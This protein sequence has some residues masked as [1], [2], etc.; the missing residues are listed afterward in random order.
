MGYGDGGKYCRICPM[1]CFWDMHKNQPYVYV[2]KIHT[3]T[4]TADDLKK[5]YEEAENKK[6]TAEQLVQKIQEEFEEVQLR[7][8]EMVDQARRSIERLNQIALRTNPLSHRRLHRH[9]H[10]QREIRSQTRLEGASRPAD[11]GQGE[12]RADAEDRA[13]GLRSVRSAEAEVCGRE[14][15][16]T[17][18]AV[19]AAQP[20]NVSRTLRVVK[21]LSH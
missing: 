20:M 4:K 9:P 19:P 13:A 10:H 3:V 12:S 21:V 14:T 16:A 5:K 2:I 6:L 11:G 1:N 8:L 18:D 17:T 7:V 15:T